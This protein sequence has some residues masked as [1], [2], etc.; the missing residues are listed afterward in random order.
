MKSEA[1][2]EDDDDEL[3]DFFLHYNNNGILKIVEPACP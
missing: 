2:T 1:F 3:I